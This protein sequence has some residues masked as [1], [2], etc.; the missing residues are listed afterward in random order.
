LIINLKN[1]IFIRQEFS[2]TTIKLP[3]LY[4]KK[5]KEK[6]VSNSE[7]MFP[8]LYQK[9]I[10]QYDRFSQ[11]FHNN[12]HSNKFYQIIDNKYLNEKIV[13]YPKQNID[14][15]KIGN[16]SIFDKE[17]PSLILDITNPNKINENRRSEENNIN[18]HMNNND[19][20]I[21]YDNTKSTFFNN[22]PKSKKKNLNN[23]EEKKL[24]YNKQYVYKNNINEEND[25]VSNFNMNKNKMYIQLLNNN[26][27]S[28]T[29]N[30]QNNNL[31]N[32]I[33]NNTNNES[34]IKNN[35][36]PNNE[37]NSNFINQNNIYN[38]ISNMFLKESSNIN[39]FYLEKKINKN[40]QR[41]YIR[42]SMEIDKDNCNT[43][44]NSYY[45]SLKD[46]IRKQRA[47]LNNT[48]LINFYNTI[49][50]ENYNNKI[51]FG[52]SYKNNNTINILNNYYNYNIN[53]DKNNNNNNNRDGIYNNYNFNNENLN[54]DNNQNS[55]K[56]SINN[57][58]DINSVVKT[59]NDESNKN[60][61][62]INNKTYSFND[63]APSN[64]VREIL[65]NSLIDKEYVEIEKKNNQIRNLICK[66]KEMT[67][68]EFFRNF[69]ILNMNNLNS[70]SLK[71]RKNFFSKSTDYK[72]LVKQ[73]KLH[74]F[75]KSKNKS[76]INKDSVLDGVY[77]VVVLKSAALKKKKKHNYFSI[78][79]THFMV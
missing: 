40:K 60:T 22:F 49:N 52:S 57:Y 27:F 7:M 61:H 41:D 64:K 70:S 4:K 16:E 63:N 39:S 62:Y 56:N 5:D 44:K 72:N 30:F 11:M 53:N 66:N 31:T 69:N 17:N 42:Y 9:K 18:T 33:N 54:E 29:V 67:Q 51:L 78:T 15:F 59:K 23:L 13:N 26:N 77:N 34:C 50:N 74:L 35:S 55:P 3:K 79:N 8:N 47:S 2:Q 73:D 71:S 1:I 21:K 14:C 65:L 48:N 46:K 68:D 38:N 75:P 36:Q 43:I 6:Y 20:T 37:D 25:I 58:E 10:I 76:K 24:Y 45:Y 28:N 32:T 12:N 19:V